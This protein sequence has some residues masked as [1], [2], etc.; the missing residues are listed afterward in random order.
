MMNPTTIFMLSVCA[1]WLLCVGIKALVHMIYELGIREGIR[2]NS[3]RLA[4]D[5]KH[6]YLIAV[7]SVTADQTRTLNREIKKTKAQIRRIIL[8]RQLEN[9]IPNWLR[10][11]II[12][13]ELL[14]TSPDAN[15][16]NAKN[17]HRFI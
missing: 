15:H 16:I 11:A 14:K 17:N 1:F 4:R 12:T 7:E 13:P 8:E 2:K 9:H 5:P 6:T 10:W 3:N